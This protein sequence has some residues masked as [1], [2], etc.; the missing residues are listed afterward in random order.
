MKL[1]FILLDSALE[2]VPKEILNDPSVIK[3]AEKRGKRPEDTMLDISLHYHAMR[4]M[5]DWQKRGR[6]DIVH[7]AMVMILSEKEILGDFYIHTYDSKVIKVERDMSPPKNYNRFIGLMEQLLKIGKIPPNSSKP[8]ME[9]LNVKLSDI[10]KKYKPILLSEDGNKVDP[11]DL[12]NDNLLLGIGAFQHSDF[13]EEVQDLFTEH[14]SISRRTLETQQV[15]CRILSS[16][17]Y[18]L[19]WP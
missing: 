16:C 2:L 7:M 8:L 3:N 9:I 19:G 1:N 11:K 14:Y 12:C 10:V 18:L 5:K 15:I 6:P 4:K 13:S 17:N